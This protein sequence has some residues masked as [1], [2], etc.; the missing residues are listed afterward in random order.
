[1]KG[2]Q[3]TGIGLR[4]AEYGMHSLRRTKAS[5]IYK[6]TGDPRAVQ[7]LLSQPSGRY[8]HLYA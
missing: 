6:A 3:A 4:C 2:D 8:T 1:M 7:I 5:M